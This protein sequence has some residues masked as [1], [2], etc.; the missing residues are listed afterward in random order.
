MNADSAPRW[1]PTLRPSQPTQTQSPPERNDSYRPHP[2]SPSKRHL[3]AIQSRLEMSAGSFAN[4]H[5]LR[6]WLD[7][8]H[9]VVDWQRRYL[10]GP[11]GC[12]LFWHDAGRSVV[13][14]VYVGGHRI[15]DCA[16]LIRFI[17]SCAVAGNVA[18]R[19]SPSRRR[20]SAHLT[21]PGRA[22]HWV[23]P[24]CIDHGGRRARRGWSVD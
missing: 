21:S 22:G 17:G 14:T 13:W 19:A 3:S 15:D 5:K 16:L 24:T 9:G 1:P 8:Q 18:G 10:V 4:I 2:P 6:L 11:D 7:I 12:G 23:W 20:T